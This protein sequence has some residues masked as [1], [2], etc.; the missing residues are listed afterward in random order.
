MLPRGQ[1]SIEVLVSRSDAETIP[2]ACGCVP[3]IGN[4]SGPCLGWGIAVRKGLHDRD[5]RR[6][7]R[8]VGEPRGVGKDEGKRAGY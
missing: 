2:D 1:G 8:V 4:V 3:V 6:V 7:T 5:R